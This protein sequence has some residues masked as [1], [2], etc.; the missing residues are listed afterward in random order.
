MKIVAN[1]FILPFVEGWQCHAS[2]FV[3]LRDGRIFAVWFYGS[4]EGKGDVRIY[5]TFRSP[6][7][8]W[9]F[10]AIPLSEDDGIP[11]WN[12]VL[13][14][15]ADGAIVL[16]YKV[17]ETIADWYTKCRVS[18]DEAQTWSDSFEMVEG[19]RSG[20]RGPVR[21]KIVRLSDGSLLAGGSTERGEWKCFFD[22]SED[23]GKTWTR[24]RDLVLSDADLVG[25]R[26][27]RGIIQPTIWESAQ[28]VHALLRSTEN[29][30]FR[31]DS[32]DGIQWCDPYPTEIPHNNSG[33]D[34]VSLPDGRLILACNPIPTNA[35]RSPISLLVSHD[36]GDHFELLTHLSTGDG[37]FA[38]PALRY[39]DGLLHVTYTWN[40]RT[41]Q[42]M[43]FSDL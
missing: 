5:G 35:L 32:P 37:R 41:L 16:Y 31:T 40:R 13:H 10:P 29:R 26:T 23:E 30:L 7:G 33:V 25:N 38:Y 19:D 43:C 4:R 8:K 22:R 36:N 24:S 34:L 20:G 1:E 39:E 14:R 11:H 21:N 42:Y 3:T 2:H 6:D 18:Y 28:G 17:G 27:K 9:T 12:P 15:R